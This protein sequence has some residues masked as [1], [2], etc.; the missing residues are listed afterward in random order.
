M[1]DIKVA[2]QHLL[3]PIGGNSVCA[4]TARH[5]TSCCL[6][7]LGLR[8]QSAAGSTA[9]IC[10]NS[11]SKADSVQSVVCMTA[12]C[13]ATYL[14]PSR[15]KPDTQTPTSG[16]AASCRASSMCSTSNPKLSWSMGIC[17][18]RAWFCNTAVKSP[19][20]HQPC[21]CPVGSLQLLS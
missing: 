18:R 5:R 8:M 17:V 9:G 4:L 20:K 10:G 3:Q 19:C 7:T 13:V 21:L 14:A 1:H 15:C 11:T 12:V 2:A 6:R 16:G